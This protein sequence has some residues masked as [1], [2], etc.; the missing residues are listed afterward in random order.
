MRTVPSALQ[1]MFEGSTVT[2]VWLL[3]V[4]NRVGVTVRLSSSGENISTAD[5]PSV[6][7]L[8]DPGFNMTSVTY[9]ADGFPATVDITI[10]VDASGPVYADHVKRGLWR[11]ATAALYVAD[12]TNPDN[13]MLMAAG[14]IG[15]S[16]FSDSISGT[17]EIATKG[18]QLGDIILF[19][20][21]PKCNYTFGDTNCGF[22]LS[23]RE[24]SGTIA[25]VTTNGKFTVTISNPDDWNFNFGGG[26]K[27]T[28]GN[29]SGDSRIIRKWTGGTSLVELTEPFC[30]DVE[31]GDTFTMH[32]GCAR[33]RAACAGYDR[34]NSYSGYDYTPGE[35]YGGLD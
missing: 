13:R 4:A 10:P 20:V 25:S 23:T 33:N 34:L 1:T 32:A 19:K 6:T 12:I 11:K 24:L 31:V 21:Q 2:P 9:S 5:S 22:D 30:L 3:E 17:L 8:G 29:N 26:F 28:S 35:L 14:F 15:N 27:F 7:F 16:S 18:E